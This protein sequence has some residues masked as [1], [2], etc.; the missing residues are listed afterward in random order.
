MI[1]DDHFKPQAIRLRDRTHVGDATVNGHD[2]LH[3]FLRQRPQGEIIQPIRFH[4]P[5]G[6]IDEKVFEPNLVKK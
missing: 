4:V 2:E 6:N 3:P 5:I 1:S